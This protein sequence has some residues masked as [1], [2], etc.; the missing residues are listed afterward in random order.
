[1]VGEAFPCCALDGRVGCAG[2]V[3]FSWGPGFINWF[4]TVDTAAKGTFRL[5][6]PSEAKI[7]RARE[8]IKIS[9]IPYATVA[10]DSTQRGDGFSERARK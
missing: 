6:S 5:G 1:M 8:E 7:F 3:N 4:T 2:G 10:L 9:T